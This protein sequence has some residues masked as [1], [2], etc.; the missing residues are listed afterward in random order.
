MHSMRQIFKWA[1]AALV[2]LGVAV[3]PFAIWFEGPWGV[4]S[5]VMVMIGCFLLVL[6]LRGTGMVA[7]DEPGDDGGKPPG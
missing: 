6:C 4:L 7:P 1:G 2:A 5:L 3:F